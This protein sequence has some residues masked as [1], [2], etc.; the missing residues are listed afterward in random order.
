MTHMPL[1][2]NELKYIIGNEETVKNMESL[3][4]FPPFYRSV[5]S[6]LNDV[7][8]NLHANPDSKR[9]PDIITFAFWCRKAS[10]EMLKKPYSDT[11]NRIGR[12]VVFHI[13]PSNVAVNFAYS[14]VVGMLAGNA[15]IVR[16]PS[17]EFAQVRIICDAFQAL[18]DDGMRPYICLVQYDH[19]QDITDCFS[20]ICDTRIIWGGDQ[21]V[22]AIR[23]SPL[24]PRATEITFA[25]RYSLC[26]INA[27][28]Y[29]K[30]PNKKSV[31]QGFYNDTYLTD[32][33]ACTS[34]RLVIWMGNST[35]EA[36]DIFWSEL[37]GLVKE[38]YILQ[39][40]QAVEKHS[41][42]CKLAATHE[43]VHLTAG[44]DNMIMRVKIDNIAANLMDYR[45][46]SGYFMEYEANAIQEIL[47][48]CT[49]KCQTLS[50]YGIDPNALSEFIMT[51]RPKGIDRII[52]IGKTMD[53]ALVWDGY[54]LIR[55]LSR[56]LN[57]I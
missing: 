41:I 47:P 48:L 12:G 29:L 34:P 5:V 32:Q 35:R 53:F 26:V 54:D 27:D 31:A 17:T 1:S 18:L 45:G 30:E 11:A 6:Y 7:S 28:E 10:V 4:A 16:L 22:E 21:T 37:Y 57:I 3:P 19:S 39:P 38:E 52:P 43:G 33:N 51:S 36:Q 50:Y 20:E 55:S 14:L 8:K 24:K 40:V 56:E 46:N 44:T 23:K 42:L 15:N 13:A 9:Y 2:S 25:D 49:S